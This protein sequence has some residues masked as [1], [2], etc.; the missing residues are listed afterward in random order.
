MCSQMPQPFLTNSTI[1]HEVLAISPLKSD[2]EGIYCNLLNKVWTRNP[3]TGSLKLYP[4]TC[5]G[6]T[7]RQ[8][9]TRKWI[10]WE[11]WIFLIN[12]SYQWNFYFF[13]QINRVCT[14]VYY[15]FWYIVVC[16]DERFFYCIYF[17]LS[18]TMQ[19]QHL[20]NVK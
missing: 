4:Q 12:I 3:Q 2:L 13:L 1:P 19:L 11:S 16:I 17:F 20:C 10:V 5:Q 7:E 15:I 14:L 8:W 9:T 6:S 18:K